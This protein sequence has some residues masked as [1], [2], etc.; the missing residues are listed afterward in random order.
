MKLN[1]T[2]AVAGE[3]PRL[4]TDIDDLVKGFGREYIYEAMDKG[5]SGVFFNPTDQTRCNLVE[6]FEGYLDYD[7]VFFTDD[8]LDEALK[9]RKYG[10]HY[11]HG[12]NCQVGFLWPK[13]N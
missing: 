10:R 2:V 6:I 4:L 7:D 9:K 3:S 12:L 5:P 13:F 8:E 11:F 1:D